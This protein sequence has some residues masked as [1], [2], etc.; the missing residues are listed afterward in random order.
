M[1]QA[2]HIERSDSLRIIHASDMPQAHAALRFVKAI[3][4]GTAVDPAWAESRLSIM[5]PEEE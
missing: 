3:E 4:C 5:R 2:K 1:L